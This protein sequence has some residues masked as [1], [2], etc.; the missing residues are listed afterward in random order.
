[1]INKVN[2]RTAQWGKISPCITDRSFGIEQEYLTTT[3]KENC[4]EL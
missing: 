4:S 2:T 1:M 3:F